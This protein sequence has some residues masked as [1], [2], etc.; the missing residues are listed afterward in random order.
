M[1]CG[2]RGG[3]T[4][5][6]IYNAQNQWITVNGNNGDIILYHDNGDGTMRVVGYN[7]QTPYLTLPA[8][9][10]FNG[11]GTAEL[12]LIGASYNDGANSTFMGSGYSDRGINAT[13]NVRKQ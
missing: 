6:E 1:L 4:P 13:I 5:V 2:S 10:V 9:Y 8:G 11:N 3:G 7:T 12:G